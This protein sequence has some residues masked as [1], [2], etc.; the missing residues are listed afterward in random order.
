MIF[1]IILILAALAL[2]GA[3]IYD[4]ITGR[5]V[6]RKVLWPIMIGFAAVVIGIMVRSFV[7]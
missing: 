1:K 7:D 6:T 4:R 3:M 2:G 5:R